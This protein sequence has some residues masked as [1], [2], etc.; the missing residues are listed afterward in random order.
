MRLKAN[1][2]RQVSGEGME[3]N[4]NVWYLTFVKFF[5]L[6]HAGDQ[7]TVCTIFKDCTMSEPTFM[8]ATYSV[9]TGSVAVKLC[10]MT[11]A[12]C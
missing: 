4:A 5:K 6:P 9:M 7:N 11:L 8:S 12:K 3:S 1:V 2:K 10:L